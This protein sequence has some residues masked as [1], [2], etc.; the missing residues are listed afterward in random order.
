LCLPPLGALTL[1]EDDVVVDLGIKPLHTKTLRQAK[2]EMAA[3]GLALD[4]VSDV[5]PKQHLMTFI[6]SSVP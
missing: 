1:Q 6:R 3:V 5:L 4:R 2:K